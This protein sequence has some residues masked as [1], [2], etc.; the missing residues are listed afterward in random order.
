MNKKQNIYA[1]KNSVGEWVCDQKEIQVPFTKHFEN[2]LTS[3]KLLGFLSNHCPI[4]QQYVLF[5]LKQYELVQERDITG[6]PNIISSLKAHGKDGFHAI[7]YKK[8]WSF[9]GQDAIQVI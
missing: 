6:A 7:F 3:F 8:C 1:I 4:Y 5:D 9:V 2:L